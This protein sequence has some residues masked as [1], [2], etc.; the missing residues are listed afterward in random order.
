MNAKYV[1][2][3]NNR[4]LTSDPFARAFGMAEA[5]PAGTAVPSGFSIEVSDLRKKDLV[6]KNR[7][8]DVE[9]IAPVMRMKLIEPHATTNEERV[10]AASPNVAWGIEAIGADTSPFTGEDIVVAVLDTGIDAGHPAFAGVQIIEKDFT[11]EG[12]GDQNGHGTHC[13]GT[14]FGRDINGKRIGVARGV[15][16]ALIGKVLGER[17]GGSTEGICEAIQWAIQNGAN[18]ISMSLGMDFPGWVA[19]LKAGGIPENV[20]VS[21][22]LEDYRKNVML[23]ERLASFIKANGAFSQTALIVAAAGN[24]SGRRPPKPWEISVSPPAVADG[25]VSVGALG[26][27]ANG[28]AVAPFSNT[29]PNISGPGV[30]VFSAWKNGDTKSLS[31]TSMATPH[32]A[33][34]AAL[35]AD[36]LKK[37]GNFTAVQLAASLIGSGS[38][39]KFIDEFDPTDVGAGMVQCP[40]D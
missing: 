33:G 37:A 3:R 29:G 5:T 22:A 39:N 2:L 9:I 31:G 40:Q 11:G 25:I 6:A 35:W 4:L 27:A 30:D 24:E 15:K 28:F 26:V 10:Q 1:V 34:A 17:G 38:T 19:Q 16:K 18:V 14:I 8:A 21:M 7:E 13:A 36:K 12:N 20:A 32:I 23:F